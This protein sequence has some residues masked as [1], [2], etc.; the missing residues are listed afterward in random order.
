MS[1]CEESDKDSPSNGQPQGVPLVPPAAEARAHLD[2]QLREKLHLQQ[3][4]PTQVPGVAP[5][6]QTNAAPEFYGTG[7]GG[8]AVLDNEDEGEGEGEESTQTPRHP[9]SPWDY[10]FGH[11]LGPRPRG[12]TETGLHSSWYPGEQLF[13]VARKFASNVITAAKTPPPS[14]VDKVPTAWDAVINAAILASE[15]IALHANTAPN[16]LVEGGNEPRVLRGSPVPSNLYVDSSF[17]SMCF[18]HTSA[19]I[20]HVTYPRFG[21]VNNTM[22]S[23]DKHIVAL[24]LSLSLCFQSLS[25]WDLTLKGNWGWTTCDEAQNLSARRT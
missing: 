1:T 22:N 8:G 5:T 6:T 21:Q 24:P 23:A 19:R 25:L 20:S 2:P 17:S 7:D 13:R 10:T 16:S 11:L 15:V 9:Q 14:Q 12:L 18:R 3:L 4:R